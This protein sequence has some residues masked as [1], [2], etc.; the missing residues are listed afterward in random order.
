MEFADLDV[1]AAEESEWTAEQEAAWEAEI[2]A[3]TRKDPVHRKR[4][5]AVGG[6]WARFL[7]YDWVVDLMPPPS[8][9]LVE[10]LSRWEGFRYQEILD[11]GPDPMTG[12]QLGF[13]QDMLRDW[14]PQNLVLDLPMEECQSVTLDNSSRSLTAQEKWQL[15]KDLCQKHRGE[16]REINGSWRYLSP[17][18]PTEDKFFHAQYCLTYEEAKMRTPWTGKGKGKPASGGKGAGKPAS[19]GKGK[20]AIGGKGPGSVGG[21][22]GHLLDA[23]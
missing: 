13:Q 8:P 1:P 22:E 19:R 3:V 16:V 12:R 15:I 20:F 7:S 23:P 2:Q 9:W 17:P 4:S 18:F 6:F 14:K 10:A 5:P 21:N 11:A